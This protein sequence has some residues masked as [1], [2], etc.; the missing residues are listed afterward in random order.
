MTAS[1]RVTRCGEP[2][3]HAAVHLL[4]RRCGEDSLV[5]SFAEGNCRANM[6]HGNLVVLKHMP[7][8]CRIRNRYANT[9]PVWREWARVAGRDRHPRSVGGRFHRLRHLLWKVN[10]RVLGSGLGDSMNG[11]NSGNARCSEH[12]GLN[13]RNETAR[14]TLEMPCSG[15][16][17]V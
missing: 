1:A 5:D 16:R 11:G 10:Q 3:P 7:S 9:P 14:R 13:M 17:L 2:K 4:V 15:H 8:A 6:R 12:G